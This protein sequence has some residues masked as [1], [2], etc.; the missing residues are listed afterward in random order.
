MNVMPFFYLFLPTWVV[1]IVCYTFLAKRYGA[2]ESYPEAEKREEEFNRQVAAYHA[3]LA[4]KEGDGHAPVKGTSTLT[5]IIRAVWFVI[6]LLVPAILAWRVLFNSPD[7][8]ASY[9][10]R[11]C[12]MT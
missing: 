1:S 2:E 10:N 5:R 11:R 12:S 4:A 7:L 9:V 6:G 8:Y 3:E